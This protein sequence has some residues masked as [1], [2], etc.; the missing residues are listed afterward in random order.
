MPQCHI[1]ELEQARHFTRRTTPI[2]RRKSENR[3]DGNTATDTGL[4]HRFQRVYTPLVAGQ[5]RQMPP[6]RPA[7]I[8]IHDDGDML[9]RL[10]DWRHVGMASGKA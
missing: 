5:S 2:F 1:Q 8:A 10:L 7:S 4:Y 6:L 9:G 3:E